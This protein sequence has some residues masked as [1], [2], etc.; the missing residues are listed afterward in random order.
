LGVFSQSER[1]QPLGDAF[2]DASRRWKAIK[3]LLLGFCHSAQSATQGAAD[4]SALYLKA[5]IA[6]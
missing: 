3:S 6:S 2:H 5:T 1:C 4:L